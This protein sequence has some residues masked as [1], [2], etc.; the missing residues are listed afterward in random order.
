MEILINPGLWEC[1]YVSVNWFIIG[2]Q[3]GLWVVANHDLSK[4]W[5]VINWSWGPNL[6]EIQ[7]KIGEACFSLD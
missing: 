3:N 4:Y 5:L 7:I 1:M 6:S 2:L